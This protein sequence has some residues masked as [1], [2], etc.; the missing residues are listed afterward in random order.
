[1][2]CERLKSLIK[3]WYVQVQNEAMAPARMVEFMDN[4]IGECQICLRDTDVHL[5]VAK[6]VEIVLPPSKA[7]KSPKKSEEEPEEPDESD[8]VSTEDSYVD[9]SVDTD[10]EGVED[11][12]GADDPLEDDDGF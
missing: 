6:V 3:I 5:E 8:T 7:I 10:D 9:D 2:D 11:D 12:F 1:M 4:H